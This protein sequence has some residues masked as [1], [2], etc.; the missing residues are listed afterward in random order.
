MSKTHENDVQGIHRCSCPAC[1]REPDG[2]IAREHQ[3]INRLLARTDERSRRLVAGFLAQ[4]HGRGGIALLERITGLDRN[5]I[6]RGRRELDQ[7]DALPAGRLRRP[8]A[9][10]KRVEVRSPES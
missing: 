7:A 9:G 10:P 4:R 3:A 1:C 6:A 8:G 2:T 5:T